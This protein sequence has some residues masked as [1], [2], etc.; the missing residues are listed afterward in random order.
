V[1][2]DLVIRNGTVV[3]GTGA[4]SRRGDV[5]TVGDG[6]VSVGVVEDRAHC[7]VDASGRLLRA[8]R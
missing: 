8:G 5:G 2:L 1:A 4:T 3:D 6:V 7:E